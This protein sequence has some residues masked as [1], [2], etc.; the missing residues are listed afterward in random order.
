MALAIKVNGQDL[1]FFQEAKVVKSLET[2]CGAFTFKSTANSDNLFPLRV[3]DSV[4][5]IADGVTILNGFIETLQVDY[6]ASNHVITVSGRDKLSDLID[7]TVGETKEFIGNVTLINVARR[8]LDDLDLTSIEIINNA[9]DISPF[10]ASEVTSAEIG[11]GAFTFL[12]LFARKRQVILTSDEQ[13]NLVLLRAGSENAPLKLKNKRQSVDNN[14][15]SANVSINNNQ[16]YRSYIAQSQ[17]NPR[18]LEAFF[19]AQDIA[20]QTGN[21]TD[22]DIRQSRIY[23]FNSEESD[24]IE[25]LNQRANWE[26]NIRRARSF[27]YSATVQGHT[28]NGQI[29]RPNQIIQVLDEFCNIDAQLLIKNV[30]YAYSLSGGS[31]TKIVVTYKDAYTLQAEQDRRDAIRNN[32]GDGFYI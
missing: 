17:L 28:F 15:L 11:Q 10:E 19:T 9:G 2:L 21:A 23:E 27:N 16:R 6:S 18:N 31:V 12:E 3:N 1:T 8:I 4:E 25:S 14:I 22:N 29:I 13:S 26:S 20:G 32:Q 7:S 24:T 30:E 5:I